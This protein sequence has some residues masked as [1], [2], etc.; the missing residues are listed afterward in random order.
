[1]VESPKLPRKTSAAPPAAAGFQVDL[2]RPTKT[3]ARGQ[4]AV[5]TRPEPEAPRVH[6]WGKRLGVAAAGLILGGL[7]LGFARRAPETGTLA[8]PAARSNGS[9][10]AEDSPAPELPPVLALGTTDNEGRLT[11]VEGNDPSAVLRYYCAAGGA[12]DPRTPIGVRAAPVPARGIRMGVLRRAADPRDYA[13][14]IRFD[15]RSGKWVVGDGRDPVQAA[16]L[17]DAAS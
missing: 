8:A 11:R 3:Q 6:E 12:S 9:E 17:S 15:R 13:I 1:M 2:R 7:I 10:T 14:W 4:R 5:H 16:L